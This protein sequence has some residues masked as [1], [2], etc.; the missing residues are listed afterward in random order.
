MLFHNKYK[1]KDGVFQYTKANFFGYRAFIFLLFP[2][3]SII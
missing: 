2:D 3:K 1:T